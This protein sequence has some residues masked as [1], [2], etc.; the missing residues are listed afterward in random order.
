MDCYGKHCGADA[1]TDL[2]PDRR[3]DPAKTCVRGQRC[4]GTIS[5][6]QKRAG[7]P[8]SE[9]SGML[10]QAPQWAEAGRFRDSGPAIP[11]LRRAGAAPNERGGFG[12]TGHAGPGGDGRNL[13]LRLCC[14][15]LAASATQYAT[16]GRA[17]FER[18]PPRGP[19]LL[20]A[21]RSS[22]SFLRRP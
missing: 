3:R 8:R 19:S 11:A 20:Q 7:C 5:A 12:V 15:R 21:C 22:S 2:R 4:M 17:K 18:Q 14:A 1:S 6:R 9:N 16:R 10:A 13:F